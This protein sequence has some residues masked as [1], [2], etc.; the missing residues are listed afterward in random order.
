MRSTMVMMLTARAAALT[1][2]AARP[3]PRTL[4]RAAPVSSTPSQNLL[5]RLQGVAEDAL[6]V[7]Q[8]TGP[9]AVLGRTVQGQRA[10][11]ETL[12]ELRNDLPAPPPPATI[13]KATQEAQRVAASGGD[14]ARRRSGHLGSSFGAAGGNQQ[15][16][17]IR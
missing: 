5:Q 11:L 3:V 14:V 1:G 12:L 8:E 2:R 17:R 13:L 16:N 4:V 6:K 15:R 7:A 9:R 10:V